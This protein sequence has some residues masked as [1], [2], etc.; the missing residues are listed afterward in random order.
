VTLTPH[1]SAVTLID[2]T[3]AQVAAKFAA[4]VRGEAVTGIVDRA[5]G[6]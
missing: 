2:A 4:I 1:V 5:R 6:Y 3:A